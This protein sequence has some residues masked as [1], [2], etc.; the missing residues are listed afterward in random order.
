MAQLAALL[1]KPAPVVPI[2]KRV[3]LRPGAS[4]LALVKWNP[5]QPRVPAG[6]PDGGQW[7][8]GGGA[9]P[10]PTGPSTDRRGAGAA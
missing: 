8:D 3:R 6:S 1:R 2:A 9:G 7:G 4:L 5:D 10:L